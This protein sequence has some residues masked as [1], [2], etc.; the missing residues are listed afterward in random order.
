MNKKIFLL[1]FSAVVFA[2]PQFVSAAMPVVTPEV[3]VSSHKGACQP[4]GWL[5]FANGC[6]GTQS[7]IADCA[8]SGNSCCVEQANLPQFTKNTCDTQNGFCSNRLCSDTGNNLLGMCSDVPGFYCC[9]RV[10]L[11]QGTTG[12]G[13]V[14]YCTTTMKGACVPK[15]TAGC[16]SG[17]FQVATCP[18]VGTAQQVCCA[19][20]NVAN[21]PL[22]GTYQLLEKIP[23]ST[24]SMTESGKLNVYL[25]DIYN[26]AFWAI[27]IAVVFMLTIGGFLYLT[28][29]GNTSRIGTAKTIIFDAFLGLILALVAWIFLN[30]INPDLVKM[31]LPTTVKIDPTI[32]APAT[33]D[34]ASGNYASLLLTTAGVTINAAGSCSD[35]SGTPVS[36]TLSLQ[37]QSAN[38]QV[39][40][41]KAGCPG[42]GACEAKTQL[43]E[44]MLK[45]L[46]DLANYYPFTIT[47]FT[48]GDHSSGSSHYAGRAV[49]IVPGGAKAGW[50]EVQKYLRGSPTTASPTKGSPY[51]ASVVICDIWDATAKKNVSVNCDS[52]AADHIHIH[53]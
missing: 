29:A 8:V 2:V 6:T 31:N 17:K 32:P 11:S 44:P 3:C 28:S 34:G 23:G 7:Y 27:G 14:D 9:G 18:N 42:T 45:A 24:Y 52:P 38:T 19:A 48:G 10:P 35:S 50:L 4:R 21:A 26:F 12:P 51:A 36:P 15:T 41:C 22:T 43:Y 39:T 47:S 46:I 37:E 33:G 13:S 25:Q 1:F 49:D 5:G 20:P 30:L 53:W 16:G 40:A